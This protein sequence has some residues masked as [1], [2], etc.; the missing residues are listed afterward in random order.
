MDKK[1]S[2][3]DELAGVF[4]FSFYLYAKI[5]IF[6]EISL[7]IMI[8]SCKNFYFK[9]DFVSDGFAAR[10][11][12]IFQL[13]Q[14]FG[15][16]GSVFILGGNCFWNYYSKMPPDFSKINKNNFRIYFRREL[17]LNLLFPNNAECVKSRQFQ[18]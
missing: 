13:V 4:A 1:F 10:E 6:N 7:V 17:F 5:V 15:R 14:E 18:H 8:L 2:A 11:S 12:F 3:F 9:V 16:Y